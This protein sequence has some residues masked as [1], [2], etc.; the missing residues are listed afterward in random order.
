M[1]P[2][3]RD[4]FASGERFRGYV[5]ERLLGK[6]GLGAVYLVRHEMLDTLFAL[7]VLYPDVAQE[8]DSYVKRFV[9]EAK[10]AT[11]IRHPNL[12][13]VHD[14]GLDETRGLYYLVMDYVSGGDLRQR[15]RE[16]A[17]HW[18]CWLQLQPMA[19]VFP[20][21]CPDGQ[22]SPV[23]ELPKSAGFYSEALGCRYVHTPQQVILFDTEETLEQKIRLAQEFGFT[24]IIS[25]AHG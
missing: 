5:V 4:I 8:N 19:V 23:S 6:G 22:G 11:R 25:Q 13:A 3:K 1:E 16:A 18:Q 2:A 24:G 7:K 15:F 9:R 21:P 14:C 10:I 12:V 20:L 17:E